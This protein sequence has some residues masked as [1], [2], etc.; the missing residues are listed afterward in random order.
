MIY[1]VPTNLLNVS[2]EVSWWILKNTGY[3]MFQGLK[4][5]ISS[6]GSH[7]QGDG[8]IGEEYNIEDSVIIIENDKI[9]EQLDDIQ[10]LLREQERERTRE[11]QKSDLDK[12]DS[13]NEM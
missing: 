9:L 7:P 5:G 4:Y 2:L 11:K 12:D 6:L 13:G 3:Y 1:F 8:K 10:R